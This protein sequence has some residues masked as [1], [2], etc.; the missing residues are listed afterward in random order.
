MQKR[1]KLDTKPFQIKYNAQEPAVPHSIGR[2]GNTQHWHPQNSCWRVSGTFQTQGTHRKNCLWYTPEDTQISLQLD[3]LCVTSSD[4]KA[5]STW[6]CRQG[7]LKDNR[8]A[9]G[10]TTVSHSFHTVQHSS[11]EKMAKMAKGRM[12]H[13]VQ[14]TSQCRLRA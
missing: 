2:G 1:W 9:Q 6:L 14:E 11:R 13:L 3:H 4:P 12:T 5:Q 8:L 7:V 10:K